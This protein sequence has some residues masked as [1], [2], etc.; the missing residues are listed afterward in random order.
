ME[1]EGECRDV[2]SVFIGEVLVS[3]ERLL[4]LVFSQWDL[5]E[6]WRLFHDADQQLVNVVL[7]FMDVLLL[8][9]QLLLL[10]QQELD[11]FIMGQ[12]IILG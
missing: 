2:C 1:E 10:L 9:A 3:G 6:C 4:G 7:Q 12:V 11:E 8:L 5:E